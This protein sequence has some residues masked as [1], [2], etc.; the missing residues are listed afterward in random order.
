VIDDPL[1]VAVDLGAGSGRVF[2]VDVAPDGLRLEEL[3]RFTSPA[4]QLDRL[5]RWDFPKIFDEIKAGLKN[6]GQRARELG[7]RI[8]SIGV[9]SWAVDYGLID[10]GGELIEN[11]VCYRD[12]RTQG[13]T[14]HVFARVPRQEI[15]EHTGIQFL[16]F[17]TLF[18]LQAHA[19]DRVPDEAAR[20]L[21]IP[22]L[23]NFFLTGR[24]V[25]EYTNASTTQ[26]VNAASGTWAREM[27]D[28]LELPSSLLC[29]IVPAGSDLGLLKPALA[30]ELS[31]EGVR[32]VAPATHDTASAIAGTPLRD[33]W[34]FI[35]S[36][37]WS[38]V[39]VERETPLIN[40]EVARFNLTNEGGA[41]GTIRF[42]KNVMGLWIL[43]SCRREWSER[44]IDVDYESLLEKVSSIEGRGA[45]IYPDDQRYFN[46]PFMLD[47]ILEQLVET[48]SS[49]QLISSN[50]AFITRTILDSLALRY[51]SILRTIESLTGRKIEGVHIVGGGS[52]NEYLNQATAT[53]TGLPVRA[54]PVEATVIGNVL[55]QAI[56]AGRFASLANAR[57]YVRE[58]VQLK[59]YEPRPSRAWE[60]AAR[61]YDE[62]ERRYLKDE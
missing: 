23:V 9:D 4:S 13:V 15:F 41:F 28:R 14:E 8:V 36:G 20:L 61:R 52:R 39:G 1:Y 57:R 26:M 50:P 38:L 48:G 22:D 44:G 3:R 17:N 58:H 7:R 62:I 16:P 30:D 2:L 34:A 12:Q 46:P 31:L 24:A 29:E 5:L 10:A 54:G 11:P 47:A 18:Q 43:E 60:E 55:V 49:D 35:S 51:A 56:A 21:M 37:T 45:I 25:T 59:T 33:G 27:L 40:S 6:A 53:A 19:A 42:L 32:V